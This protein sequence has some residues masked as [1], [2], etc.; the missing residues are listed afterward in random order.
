MRRVGAAL[1]AVGLLAAATACRPSLSNFAGQLDELCAGH[2]QAL[3]TLSKPKDLATANSFVAVFSSD[4][5]YMVTQLGRL[6]LPRGDDAKLGPAFVGAFKSASAS[7]K[8]LAG[9]LAGQDFAGAETAMA[10]TQAAITNADEVGRRLGSRVCA[11]DWVIAFGILT[12]TLPPILKSAYIAK[13]DERCAA[14]LKEFEALP[15]PKSDQDLAI[16]FETA[17]LINQRMVQDLRAIKPPAANQ[18]DVDKIF[19]YINRS[20]DKLSEAKTYAAF[21][22][23]RE[24]GILLAEIRDLSAQATLDADRFGFR[25]CGSAGSV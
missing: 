24:V 22:R 12:P 10:K 2:R 5:D 3:K 7:S 9:A 15:E 21:G 23:S 8:N 14:A 4:V 13:A 6:K 16:F 11:K 19:S 1:L 20:S 18:A 25:D 17:A